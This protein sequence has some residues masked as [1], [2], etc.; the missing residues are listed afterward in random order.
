MIG[1]GYPDHGVI[2][3]EHGSSFKPGAFNWILDP[4]D[5]TKSFVTGKPLFGTLIGLL[6]DTRPILG[7]IEVP[8]LGERWTG[9]AGEPSRVNGERCRTS[10]TSSLEE[11][12]LAATTIDMFSPQALA[13]FDR[14]SREVRFRTFGGDCYCYG[15][16]ASGF[17]DLVVEADLAPYDCLPL[18]PVVTG[19]GGRITDW[20]GA[21]L[22]FG[23]DRV[24]VAAAASHE[25]HALALERLQGGGGAG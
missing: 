21:E 13:S 24:E 25:L 14:L 6:H 22:R 8:A 4:I 5:G 15:L 19:A 10:A 23:A 1:S 17:V 2:G 9:A 3:E 7:V 12:R 11:A 18:V 20:S 16:L